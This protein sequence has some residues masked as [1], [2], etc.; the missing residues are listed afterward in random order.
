MFTGIIEEV[1]EVVSVASIANGKQL[2]IRAHRV[3]EGT[4]IGDS[5]AVDGVC[6]TV[7]DLANDH[8]TVQAVGETLEKTTLGG[9]RAPQYVNLERALAVG[10]RLGGHFVQGHVNGMG[11]IRTLRKRGDNYLLEVEI[12][13]PLRK[14]IIL[15][16]SIAID[17]ISLTVAHLQETVVG[18][19]I[20]P[21]T[22]A[23]TNL[24]YKRVGQPVNIE[25]DLIAKYIE[26]LLRFGN[27][28][29]LN[30]NLLK[31]WGY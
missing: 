13:P 19:N 10:D 26:N 12:P 22:M 16:G 5:I 24:Q 11:I 17:G 14:Y 18:I 25:V 7:T 15:E 21:H 2:T 3:L 23:N 6:L 29:K 8:F 1:G 20:I 9:V 31:Q 28:E 4:Q 30:Q 27:R